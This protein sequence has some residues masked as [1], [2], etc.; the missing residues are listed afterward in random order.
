MGLL[1]TG[2]ET[3]V[4]S[5]GQGDLL[6]KGMPTYSSTF[7]WKTPRTEEPGGLQSTGSQRVG[8]DR[9]TV[10]SQVLLWEV[11]WKPRSTHQVDLLNKSNINS[12]S[13]PF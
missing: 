4:R 9:A 6:Q 3:Q 13:Y 10:T 11:P 12:N 7:A 1:A 2:Q 8:H 5:L